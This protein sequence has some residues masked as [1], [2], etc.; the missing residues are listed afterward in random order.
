MRFT[1]LVMLSLCACKQSTHTSGDVASCNM[2]KVSNCREYNASNLA[3]GSDHVAKLCGVVAT[4]TFSMT[5]C[6]KA[7]LIGKCTNSEH[8]DLYYTGYPIPANELEMAC[9]T[10]GGTFTTAP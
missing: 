4:G 2:P 8:A 10:S 3:M 6:P 7:N 9:K 1:W 5:A